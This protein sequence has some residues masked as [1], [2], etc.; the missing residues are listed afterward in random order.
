VKCF[1]ETSATPPGSPVVPAVSPPREERQAATHA[2]QSVQPQWRVKKEHDPF[3]ENYGNSETEMSPAG[4][5]PVWGIG[6]S[7]LRDP[8]NSGFAALGWPSPKDAASPVP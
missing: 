7:R 1:G 5:P 2:H 8:P 3:D 6:G 4:W